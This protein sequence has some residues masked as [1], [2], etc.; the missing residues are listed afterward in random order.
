ML[1]EALKN[2][3][4]VAFVIFAVIDLILVGTT[5]VCVMFL[6]RKAMA[7]KLKIITRR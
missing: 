1:A 2:P 3:L 7:G 6:V 4:F 5:S